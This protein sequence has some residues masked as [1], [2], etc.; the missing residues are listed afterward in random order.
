MTRADWL[1]SC[2]LARRGGMIPTT[3][4]MLLAAYRI[5]MERTPSPADLFPEVNWL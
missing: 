2:A 1:R 5:A 3:L 4:P